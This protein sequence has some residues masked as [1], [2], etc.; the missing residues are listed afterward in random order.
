M[1]RHDIGIVRVYLPTGPSC[2]HSLRQGDSGF[3]REEGTRLRQLYSPKDTILIPHE[4]A[5]KAQGSLRHYRV[6]TVNKEREAPAPRHREEVSG[7]SRFQQ[8]TICVERS[9]RQE[10]WILWC[11]SDNCKASDWKELMVNRTIPNELSLGNMHRCP[12]K[13]NI[14][15]FFG[16]R[17][18]NGMLTV[19]DVSTD[20]LL[21]N[22]QQ[23][24][25][26]LST[27]HEEVIYIG[28][29]PL[30]LWGG[31]TVHLW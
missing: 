29:D 27:R 25:K 26:L 15:S 10:W 22:N 19:F 6:G 23:K 13:V 28:K 30:I 16:K 4:N 1:H 5:K 20:I 8:T 3:T 7:S 14:K 12:S 24:Y 18:P 9:C 2:K 31:F 17:G 21:Q 11:C